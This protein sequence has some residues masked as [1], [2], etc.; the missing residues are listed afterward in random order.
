M[1]MTLLLNL[2]NQ[3]SLKQKKLPVLGAED[4]HCTWRVGRGA[5]R[6]GTVG[7]SGVGVG[8]T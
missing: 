4:V 2:R 1:S 8:W 7:G 6:E 3:L 5:T